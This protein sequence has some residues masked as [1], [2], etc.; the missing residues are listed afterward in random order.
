MVAYYEKK[1]SLFLPVNRNNLRGHVMLM[2]DRRTVANEGKN[3][4]LDKEHLR[5][6][7]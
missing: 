6:L 4:I 7:Q 2:F 3:S 5:M 1:M